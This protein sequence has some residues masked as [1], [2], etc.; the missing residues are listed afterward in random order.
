MKVAN[1]PVTSAKRLLEGLLQDD[2]IQVKPSDRERFMRDWEL[3][4]DDLSDAERQYS[5]PAQAPAPEAKKPQLKVTKV[6]GGMTFH[7]GKQVR[8]VVAAPTQ[9]RAAE[10]VGMSVGEFRQFWSVTG[11]SEEVRVALSQP[12]TVFGRSFTKFDEQFKPFE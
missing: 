8:A 11:N 7:K 6:F 3:A 4:M 2:V 5:S 1:N 9:K 12:E 10:L